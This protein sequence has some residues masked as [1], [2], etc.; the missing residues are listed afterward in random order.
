[1]QGILILMAAI[2]MTTGCRGYRV[3][4]QRIPV[5]IGDA[6]VELVL[7]ETSAPFPTYIS[8]HDNENTAV[9]AALSV[10]RRN[11]GRLIEL[12]HTGERNVTFSLGDSIY[13]FDPNRIFT[14]NGARA[15]L[16]DLGPFSGQALQAVRAFADT[17]IHHLDL[18][19][20]EWAVTVHNNTEREYSVLSYIDRGEYAPDVRFTYLEAAEDPDDFFYVTEER[21]YTSM[22]AARFNVV[23]QDNARVSDDGSLSVY[24][25]LNGIPYINVEA[26][27]GHYEEQVKMLEFVNRLRAEL[28]QSPST[29]GAD[30]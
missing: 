26:Q 1:M 17:L 9:E 21:F 27:H 16:E 8:L 29:R 4:E 14:E 5:R 6:E 12:Q 20:N 15:T 7:H 10:I 28:N 13:V 19:E 25:G 24:C 30:R 23:M 11:G 22:R 18:P 3:S 2:L